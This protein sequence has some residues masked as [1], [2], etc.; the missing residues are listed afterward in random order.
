MSENLAG[1]ERN[2]IPGVDFVVAAEA[3]ASV[4]INL[5]LSG[6]ESLDTYD[7]HRLL[8][9]TVRTGDAPRDTAI[10]IPKAKRNLFARFS[11]W[12]VSGR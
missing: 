5:L 12:M 10:S 7:V 1:L 6:L 11:L 8:A 4:G 2:Q 9:G 3:L